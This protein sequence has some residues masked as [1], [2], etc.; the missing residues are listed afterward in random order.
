MI[1]E[2]KNDLEMQNFD[3]LIKNICS[4]KDN[5][6]NC[7]EPVSKSVSSCLTDSE[8]SLNKIGDGILKGSA[9]FACQNLNQTTILMTLE[10]ATMKQNQ[11]KTCFEQ[12]YEKILSRK[13]KTSEDV[14]LIVSQLTCPVY[15]NFT[16]CVVGELRT[17]DQAISAN[18]VAKLLEEIKNETP[19]GTKNMRSSSSSFLLSF[20]AL[21]ISMLI[22][23]N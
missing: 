4:K 2:L 5:F 6:F 21:I 3:A 7:V 19:C 8:K 20:F 18:L 9:K 15:K 12:N 22:S 23:F 13:P 11:L 1:E 10:C 17:C 14:N 16:D